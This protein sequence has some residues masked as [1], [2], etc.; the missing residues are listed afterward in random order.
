MDK[1]FWIMATLLTLLAC[2]PVN[3]ANLFFLK[4]APITGLDD[5]DRKILKE[6]AR[7]ALENAEDGAT[8]SW[9]N[10]KT[11]HF[12]D[13]TVIDT[14]KDYGTICRTVHFFLSAAN[15]TGRS[16]FRACKADDDTWR[17]APREQ[18]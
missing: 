12:G 1:Y 10:P 13:I 17:L 8:M 7:D 4:D 3:A 6:T 14:H 18:E 15:K 11:G 5:E 2:A 9:K 16:E